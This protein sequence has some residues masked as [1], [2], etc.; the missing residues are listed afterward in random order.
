MHTYGSSTSYAEITAVKNK[1][2]SKFEDCFVVVFKD[3][4]RITGDDASAAI[5]K[6]P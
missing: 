5:K 1:L 6:Q 4:E 3:G 2:R